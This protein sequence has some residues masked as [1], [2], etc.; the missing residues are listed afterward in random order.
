LGDIKSTQIET[1]TIIQK[2]FIE[3][4]QKNAN[5]NEIIISGNVKAMIPILRERLILETDD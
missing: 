3:H 1:S 5:K 4:S 2:P